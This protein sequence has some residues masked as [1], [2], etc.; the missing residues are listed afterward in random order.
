MKRKLTQDELSIASKSL[1]NRKGELEWLEYQL[2]Y[3]DL[4]LTQGIEINYKK[5]LREYKNQKTDI[6]NQIKQVKE[7]ISTLGAQMRDGVDVIED[8]QKGG[9]K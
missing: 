4:M 6:E 5:T 9:K 3:H 7:I 8:K 1:T 2:K